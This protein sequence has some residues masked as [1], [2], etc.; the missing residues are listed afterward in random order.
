MKK[1]LL[2][3]AA[4]GALLTL[5][6][7]QT[8]LPDM[9]IVGSGD[10]SLHIPGAFAV[11][12]AEQIERVQPMS[13]QDML[14]R[15]SGVHVVETDGYGLAP[16]IGLRGLNPD[17]SKKVLLLEDG[18]PIQMGPFIDPAAYYSPPV[19]RMEGME[20]LKGS[21]SLR[22]GP[23]TV[24]GAIN[25]ITRK[26]PQKQ[27]TDVRLSAHNAGKGSLLSTQID[28]G[29]THGNAGY[30]IS[31]I[32]KTGD[33][34]KENNAIDI[35]DLMVKTTLAIADNQVLSTKFTHYSQD[36]QTT[37]LGLTQ[38]EYEADHLQNKA[39]NDW[40][41]GKRYSFDITHEIDL[42]PEA[43]L[44]T[45]AYW[46]NTT[47]DW[48]REDFAY[49]GTSGGCTDGYGK[50]VAEGENYMRDSL[51]AR[52]RT[53]DVMGID[54]RLKLSHGAFGMD[55]Q[56][57]IGLRL[58]TEEMENKRIDNKNSGSAR[59]GEL[60]EHDTRGAD[61]IALFAQNRFMPS[62]RLSITPGVRVEQYTQTRDIHM[63]GVGNEVNSSSRVRNTE[64]IPGIGATY[65]LS[66]SATLFGGI[67][68]GFS[69]ARVQDAIDNSGDEVQLEA[70]RSTNVEIGV[71]GH[72][73]EI[74]YE[75]TAFHYDFTNQIVQSSE[76]GGAASGNTNA[77]KTL[78]QGLEASVSAPLGGG[79]ST[80]VALTYIPT[81]KLSSKRIIGGEDRDGNRVPY[82]PQMLARLALSYTDGPLRGTLEMQHTG[83]QYTDF[84][85]TKAGSDDGMTGEID[86][87]TLFNLSTDYRLSPST[88]LFASVK[89][90]TDE[91]YISSRAP[92]GIFAGA[93]RQV[94]AGL[95][96]TF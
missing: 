71:R 28:T 86:A 88:R 5:S 55:N 2:S 48:W 33:G 75:A 57:Q 41:Y 84:Q 50:S 24:G 47:R 40:F 61:A 31:Y 72:S 83:S 56:A 52:N 92:R 14:K 32:K 36:S 45:L 23:S 38:K 8:R 90:L 64:V 93:P 89:N 96:M 81:A 35:N 9:A 3:V 13:T 6:A 74:A 15:V 77:G 11:I 26:P 68:R 18:A 46:N 54:S 58:H 73:G 66:E 95:H 10:E 63:W 91:K 49:C 87:Y 53:F 70:E 94:G 85:N 22:Y 69:P 1:S 25:Y 19:E 27:T 37:Y 16:R 62:N 34:F 76:A 67:H 4:A 80:D 43:T 51:G 42:S 78:H 30:L 21:G 82:T 59:S 12:D 44:T 60:R 79:F 17:M 29:G 7:D 39:N 65:H 20:V